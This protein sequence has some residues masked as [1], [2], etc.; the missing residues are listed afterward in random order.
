MELVLTLSQSFRSFISMNNCFIYVS[1]IP[2][3]GTA[4]QNKFEE[5]IIGSLLKKARK[6]ENVEIKIFSASVEGEQSENEKLVIIPL[7]KN[8][9]GF[10]LHQF[11]LL[12]SLGLFLWQQRK[13]NVAMFVRYHDAMIAPLI[14]AFIFDI[15]LS[16]RTGPILPGLELSNKKPGPVIF[17][18]IKWVLGLFYMKASSIVTV[19]EKIK[20]WVIETYNLDPGKIVVVPNA[21]DTTLFFPESSNRKKWGLPEDEFIFGFIGTIYEE[22][23]LNTI[24]EAIGLLKKNKEKVPFLFLVGDGKCRDPLKSLA[25][26]LDIANHIV[27]AGNIPHKEVRSAINACDMMLIPVKNK[28]LKVKGSSALKLWEY[29]ACDKPVLA[30]EYPDHQFLEKLNLGRMIKPDNVELWAEALSVEAKKRDCNLRGRGHK[31]IIEEHSYDSVAEN[32]ISI[33]LATKTV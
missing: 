17:H 31:F 2:R 6:N 1:Q 33:S 26:K 29:L 16:M 13:K 20:D 11:R 21:A 18:S 19:T 15:R 30:S 14:L 3:T 28:S 7:K 24:I 10:I 27:W 5:G 23:G 32:F 12:F 8:Y 4:G 22:Q 9:P 25:E